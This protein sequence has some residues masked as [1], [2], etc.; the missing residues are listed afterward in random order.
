MTCNRDAVTINGDG[1]TSRA[2]PQ[3][4]TASDGRICRVDVVCVGAD[5][6]VRPQSTLRFDED[7][8]TL[9][10]PLQIV[11]RVVATRIDVDNLVDEVE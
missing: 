2:S 4:V 8:R 10:P 9:G 11:T 3:R 7:G 6:R 1:R 5:L